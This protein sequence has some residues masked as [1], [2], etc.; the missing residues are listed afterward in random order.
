MKVEIDYEFVE[1]NWKRFPIPALASKFK[2]SPLEFMYLIRRK[3]ICCDIQPFEIDFIFNNLKNIPISE[4]RQTLGLTRTQLD[5]ILRNKVDKEISSPKTLSIEEV[6]A[7][8]K[9]LI[10]EKL[11]LE[12][13]DFLPRIISN[14]DFMDADL[15]QCIKFA[16]DHKINDSYYKSFSAVTYLICKAYPTLY[17][18]FQFRH[19]KTNVY[20]KGKEGR[21]NLVNAAIWVISEK[22]HLTLDSLSSASKSKYFLRARDLAFYGITPKLYQ[23]HFKTLD[24]FK[25]SILSNFE[26]KN[27]V[28]QTT[29][30][31]RST[32][33][34]DGRDPTKCEAHGC[35][36]IGTI[37]IHHIIPKSNISLDPKKIH[38]ANNLIAL[39]PTHHRIAHSFDLSKH[40]REN[41]REALLL[42]LKGK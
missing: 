38:N 8:T 23:M 20:F 33:I 30:K 5:Q 25:A 19:S 32:I 39:C 27:Y 15:Y 21:K 40:P 29:N 24:N 10:E 6:I 22:M 14:T 42:H 16:N 11:Q 3:N 28:H 4:I 12:R 35:N 18:P 13:D 31:L 34:E 36:I 26:Q 17:R 41:L 1:R 7:K 9:W 2:L 37:D